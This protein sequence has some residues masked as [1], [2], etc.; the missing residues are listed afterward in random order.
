M[1]K[2]K[3]CLI[4]QLLTGWSFALQFTPNSFIQCENDSDC[5][6]TGYQICYLNACQ[7]KHFWPM[8][9]S[10]IF[11]T[12]MQMFTA[13]LALFGGVGGGSLYIPL[14]VIFYQFETKEA[15]NLSNGLIIAACFGKFCASVFDKNRDAKHMPII[16]YNSCLI[17]APMVLA[18]SLFGVILNQILPEIIIGAILFVTLSSSATYAIKKSIKIYRKEAQEIQEALKPK[19]PKIAQKD[20]LTIEKEIS[21]KLK[22][23]LSSKQAKYKISDDCI[24]IPD[25][26]F[27]GSARSIN[28]PSYQELDKF[29]TPPRH[30]Q[31]LA[32]I[33]G[34]EN[35]HYQNMVNIFLILKK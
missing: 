1:N 4:I 18:G 3:G 16:D 29:V 23:Q 28:F 31:P 7:H 35:D 21:N 19:D 20:L 12:L 17:F 15:I 13:V 24:E 14:Q 32:E 11:G 6:N 9:A 10:E 26:D 25:F 2:R 8:T 34:E 33:K 22:K 5:G 27:N 30:K